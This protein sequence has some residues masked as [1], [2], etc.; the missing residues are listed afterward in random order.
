MSSSNKNVGAYRCRVYFIASADGYVKIGRSMRPS[1]RMAD[2]QVA[3]PHQLRLL[4]AFIGGERLE[5]WVHD[6]LKSVAVRGEWFRAGTE[7]E[8]VLAT[9][10]N[11][12]Y[13]SIRNGVT[14]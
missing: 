10:R 13:E 3:N 12:S 5:R 2:L 7:T 9:L 4:D 11:G 1:A 8:N 14:T 6:Q